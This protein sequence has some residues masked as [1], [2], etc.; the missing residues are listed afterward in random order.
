MALVP[1]HYGLLAIHVT[2][3]SVTKENFVDWTN[4]LGFVLSGTATCL[5][6]YLNSK[7]R[8]KISKALY[9]INEKVKEVKG[10]C[11]AELLLQRR[12]QYLSLSWICI[13]GIVVG[14]FLCTVS[15]C[16]SLYSGHQFMELWE[17]EEFSWGWWSNIVFTEATLLYAVIYYTLSDALAIDCALQLAF[18]YRVQF[19]KVSKIHPSKGHSSTVR[20]LVNIHKELMIVNELTDEYLDFMWL[21]KFYVWSMCYLSLGFLSVALTVAVSQGWWVILRLA[22]L[23]MFVVGVMV[24]WGLVGTHFEESVC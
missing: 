1:L 20:D 17:S 24:L 4:S 11:S 15:A 13:A 5:R 19:E 3:I 7:N 6:L 18:L 16:Y 22:P 14:F 10:D 8:A 9:K 23:P 21:F 2:Q 12:L